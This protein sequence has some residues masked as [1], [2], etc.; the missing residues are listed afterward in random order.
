MVAKFSRRV[1]KFGLYLLVVLLFFEGMSRLAMTFID[2]SWGPAIP[3]QVHRFDPYLGWKLAPGVSVSSKRTGRKVTYTINDKGLRDSEV[4]YEKPEGEYRIVLL[5]DSRSF[6]FGV[7]IEQH[8]SRMLEGY[9]YKL[10]VINMGVDGYGVDQELLTLESEGFKYQPDMVM[11]YIAH[12]ANQRHLKTNV[13][14]V[15]KPCFRLEHGE[16]VLENCPV[17]NGDSIYA[18]LQDVDRKASL[19]STFYKLLR[20]LGVYIVRSM[21]RVDK[22]HPT[23]PSD[24][25]Q[26]EAIEENDEIN[27]LAE[28]IILRMDKVCREH[29]ARLFVVT[30]IESL[31]RCCEANGILVH[32]TTAPMANN[33]QRLPDGLGH[34]NEAGNG[35]LAWEIARFLFQEDVIPRTNRLD[36]PVF[37]H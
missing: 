26:A 10:D 5:G 6:G 35:A 21:Y 17:A 29:K 37:N 8:F 12:Y 13:W 7:P 18:R 32:N 4:P 16:L 23:P 14:G 24:A 30:A 27:E 31:F 34:V 19:Y 22:D 20:D 1:L 28:A 33:L 3:V 15:G 9:Y 2:K 36:I 25:L 11:V